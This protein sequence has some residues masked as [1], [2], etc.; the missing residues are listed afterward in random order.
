MAKIRAGFVDGSIFYHPELK[1]RFPVPAT[2]MLQ[3]SPM[4][5][6]MAPKDG[7]AMMLFMLAEQTSA[8]E[9]A[10]V[11]LQELNLTHLE[12]KHTTVNGMPAVATV[13]EQVSQNQQTG[14]QQTIRVMSYF[15]EYDGR[16]YVFHGVS[17]GAEFNSYA[18]LFE[19]TM[20]G[21]NRLTEASG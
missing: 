20:A 14:Q 18:R 1:F 6:Q 15:I 5:V 13:S 11:A 16:V 4:Q 19:S 7:S 3:N 2:W 17:T 21:F 8:A 9:A 12:S 10:P